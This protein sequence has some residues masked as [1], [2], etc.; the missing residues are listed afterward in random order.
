MIRVIFLLI[1]ALIGLIVYGTK[2]STGNAKSNLTA[3]KQIKDTIKKNF[4][5]AEWT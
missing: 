5:L 4:R 1:L 2:K 3:N